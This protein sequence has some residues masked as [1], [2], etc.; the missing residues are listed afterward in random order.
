MKSL[1]LVVCIFMGFLF[2]LIPFRSAFA[3]GPIKLT[4]GA[5]QSITHTFSKADVAWIDK[6]HKDTEGRVMITPYWGGTLL[7][8]RENTK[9]LIQGVADLGYISPRTGYP[10]MLGTLGYPY[11]VGDWKIVW[12]IYEEVDAKFPEIFV[13]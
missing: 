10:L 5:S 8:R 9:E 7:S 11:G 2:V 13:L 4:F 1:R 6:I 12:R 3:E